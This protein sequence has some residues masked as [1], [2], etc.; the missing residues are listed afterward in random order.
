MPSDCGPIPMLYTLTSY[1]FWLFCLSDC[2]KR[3]WYSELTILLCILSPWFYKNF[4][5]F[6]ALLMLIIL[7]I[8]EPMESEHADQERVLSAVNLQPRL[9]VNG[10]KCR[11]ASASGNRSPPHS[12]ETIREIT[13]QKKLPLPYLSDKLAFVDDQGA[14]DT[15][16]PAVSVENRSLISQLDS[17]TPA[18]QG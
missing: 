16:S 10:S 3:V 12:S 11:A 5:V 6:P 1:P 2:K 9:P 13:D 7:F 8:T 4:S 17:S 14:P 15:G 18:T